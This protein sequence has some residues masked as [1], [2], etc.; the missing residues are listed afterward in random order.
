MSFVQ[1]LE[2]GNACS[3]SAVT[4]MSFVA[5][6]AVIGRVDVFKLGPDNIHVTALLLF[7]V[8]VGLLW[9]CLLFDLFSRWLTR[10]LEG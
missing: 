5:Y 3:I 1:N 10:K 7:G 6:M 8:T 2:K 9:I 4:F